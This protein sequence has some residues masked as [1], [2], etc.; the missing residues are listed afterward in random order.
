MLLLPRQ[1]QVLVD[2]IGILLGAS[3]SQLAAMLDH[4]SQILADDWQGVG[5]I[6]GL[7]LNLLHVRDHTGDLS[8]L[9]S[10]QVVLIYIRWGIWLVD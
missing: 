4:V 5:A 1:R 3:H 2:L 8:L 10:R 7:E 9:S 6:S